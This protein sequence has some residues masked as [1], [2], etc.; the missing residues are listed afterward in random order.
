MKKEIRVYVCD[1]SKDNDNKGGHFDFRTSEKYQNY[2]EIKAH[3]EDLG[4][5]YSLLDFQDAIN[6]EV[7]DLSNSFILIK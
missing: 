7:L 1:C 4:T 6:D 5:V 3:A 2:D